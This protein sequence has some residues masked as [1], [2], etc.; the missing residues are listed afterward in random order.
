[1]RSMRLFICAAIAAAALVGLG[2]TRRRAEA[3]RLAPPEA[4][5]AEMPGRA[6]A[7]FAGDSLAA[8]RTSAGRGEQAPAAAGDFSH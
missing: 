7:R 8:A 1:M 2:T 3:A 5:G 4:A 6:R